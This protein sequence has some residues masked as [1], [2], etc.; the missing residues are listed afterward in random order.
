M[1]LSITVARGTIRLNAREFIIT[2]LKGFIIRGDSPGKSQFNGS[3]PVCFYR[4]LITLLSFPVIPVISIKSVSILDHAR[5]FLAM[6][7]HK[8]FRIQII[9]RLYEG[10][11]HLLIDLLLQ[12]VSL[13]VCVRLC[14][15]YPYKYENYP[16]HI[17]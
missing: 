1:E 14:T 17:F 4:A 8:S 3:F 15:S 6:N 9:K 13:C 5:H 11:P 16:V 7:R 12:T 2:H 10:F